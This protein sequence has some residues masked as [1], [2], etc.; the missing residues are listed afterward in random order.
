MKLKGK[1][2]I[3]DNDV[4]LTGTHLGET[5]DAVLNKQQIEIDSLKGNVKWIY[6]NGGVGGKGGSGG[7]GSGDSWSI[8]ATLDNTQLKSNNIILNGPGIYKLVVKINKPGGGNFKCDVQYKNENGVQN[9][10]SSYLNIDNVFT[11]TYNIQ[12][13]INDTINVTITDENGETKQVNAMYIVN[14]Y[15]F[16]IKYTKN[17][18]QEYYNEDNDIFM[19]DIVENGLGIKINYSI[20]IKAS[21]Q[22]K[23]SKFDGTTTD[24]I[25][26]D[27]VQGSGESPLLKIAEDAFYADSSNAGYYT[28]HVIIEITPENQQPTTIEK[29]LSCNLI[30]RNLYL[31]IKTSTGLIYRDESEQNPYQFSPGNVTFYLQPYQGVNLNRKYTLV[32]EIN[33][34]EDSSNSGILNERSNTEY[35]F[36]MQQDGWNKIK[37][38]LYSSNGHGSYSV[39]KYLYIYNSNSNLNFDTFAKNS[40]LRV[41]HLSTNNQSEHCQPIFESNAYLSMNKLNQPK[42]VNWTINSSQDLSS[43]L[44]NIGFELSRTVSEDEPLFIL[45][46]IDGITNS[47]DTN[48]IYIYRNKIKIGQSTTLDI[49][50]PACD[51]LGENKLTNYHL[52][53]IHK[54]YYYTAPGSNTRYFELLV[55]IDGKLENTTIINANPTYSKLVF[56]NST[57]NCNFLD[58]LQ[59]NTTQEKDLI[60]DS[61]VAEYFYTWV[62]KF[63][64]QDLV[65]NFNDMI[66]VHNTIHNKFKL[67]SGDNNKMIEIDIAAV[68][69][70]A[71]VA[72][73][74]ILLLKVQDIK[75]FQQGEGVQNFLK[76]YQKKYNQEESSG[77]M[78]VTVFYS[79]NKSGLQEYT[80]DGG[81]FTI[82]VQ[83]SSTKQ[84]FA[85]N[86][87]LGVE[88][89]TSDSSETYI[90][91][92]NFINES[93]P[94]YEDKDIHNTFLPET[95]FTLKADKVDSSHCNNNA[96]GAF[97]NDHTVKFKTGDNGKYKNY[98][99]NCLTGFA[100]LLFVQTNYRDPI[101]QE[102]STHVYYLGVYNFNLGRKSY[103]NLGYKSTDNLKT[104]GLKNGFGIYKINKDLNNKFVDGLNV[105]EV[106]DND[107][108]W[109]F[110]Q[111]DKL[112]LSGYND[113]DKGMYDDFVSNDTSI[114]HTNDIEKLSEFTKR[115]SLAGGYAF[116]QMGKNF[117][118]QEDKYNASVYDTTHI[119]VDKYKSINQV[120]DYRQQYTR[121]VDPILNKIVYTEKERINEA[122]KEDLL[123]CVAGNI[124][125]GIPA[126]VDYQSL[127]EYYVIC[128]AFGMLDSVQ[129]NL[130]VK[131]WNGGKTYYIAFYDM[132]T[133]L[134]KDNDGKKVGYFAYSDYWTILTESAELIDA[135]VQR[136]F[137]PKGIVSTVSFFDVPS[138]YLFAIAKYASVVLDEG[139]VTTFPLKLWAQFR[140][141]IVDPKLHKGCLKNADYFIDNYFSKRLNTIGPELLNFNYRAKYL[142]KEAN[143][144]NYISD[145]GS[146]QGPGVYKVKDWLNSRLH[147]L[148]VYMGLAST[149]PSHRLIQRY[150]K[151][152]SSW[153]SLKISGT[154]VYETELDSQEIP[155]NNPDIIIYK[156]IFSKGE[157]RKYSNTI[158]ISIKVLDQSFLV[159]AKDASVSRY[160]LEDSTKTYSIKFD[161]SGAQ[162]MRLGGSDRWTYISNLAPFYIGSTNIY[163]NSYNLK[164]FNFDKAILSGTNC[165]GD[166]INLPSCEEIIFSNAQNC[167]NDAQINNRNFPIV[168][169]ID[170]STSKMGNVS[171]QN[172]PLEKF[173]GKDMKSISLSIAN[174]KLQVLDLSDSTFAGEVFLNKVLGNPILNNLQCK[175]LTIY[176]NGQDLIINNNYLLEELN[177][178]GFRKIYVDNCPKLKTFQCVDKGQ[179]NTILQDLK[180]TNC[181]TSYTSLLRQY[182]DLSKCKALEW[183][184]M[185]NTKVF[186]ALSISHD[187][188]LYP[189]A[190]ENTNLTHIAGGY[191]I[192]IIITGPNTFKNTPYKLSDIENFIIS[193]DNN[194]TN[195]SSMFSNEIGTGEFDMESVQQFIQYAEN[196]EHVTN[197]NYLFYG[198]KNI[199]TTLTPV[200]Y[201]TGIKLNRFKKVKSA[202]GVFAKTQYDMINKDMFKDFGD[203]IVDMNGFFGPDNQNSSESNKYIRVLEHTGL[204]DLLLKI[205]SL[206]L[207]YIYP[208]YRTIKIVNTSNQTVENPNIVELFN[209][210][211]VNSSNIQSISNFNIFYDSVNNI[212]PNYNNLFDSPNWS[213][214]RSLFSS[215]ISIKIDDYKNLK[216]KK[217]QL[218]SVSRSLV[219]IYTNTLIDMFELLNWEYYLTNC[220]NQEVIGDAFDGT[221]KY[222]TK[223]NWDKIWTYISQ[224]RNL[225][226]SISYL[227]TRTYLVGNNAS[228]PVV[229][230][231]IRSFY[232]TFLNLRIINDITGVETNNQLINLD[233]EYMDIDNYPT[234]F[235]RAVNWYGAFHSCKILKVPKY[236]FFNKRKKVITPVYKV[237]IDGSGIKSNSHTKI[238]LITY[239]YDKVI[240]NLKQTFESVQFKE[241]TYNYQSFNLSNSVLQ[242]LDGNDL[243]DTEYYEKVN[244][245]ILKT[246]SPNEYDYD[247]L[248]P[249]TCI[250]ETTNYTNK[251]NQQWINTLK[252]GWNQGEKLGQ[253]IL[254]P[255]FFAGCTEGCNICN[256]FKDS[257]LIGS[258][259]PNLVQGLKAPSDST[260]CLVGLNILPTFYGEFT[261]KHNNPN[262]KKKRVY[263]FV[264]ENFFNMGNINN[265]IGVI[266]RIPN[267]QI[268][269]TSNQE[270]VNYYYLLLDT[271]FKIYPT[272]YTDN[273]NLYGFIQYFNYGEI[274]INVMFNTK[275]ISNN[276][277]GE[278]GWSIIQTKCDSLFNNSYM[279]AASGNLFINPASKPINSWIINNYPIIN[280]SISS[281]GCIFPI[282]TV[283]LRN[284]IKYYHNQAIYIKNVPTTSRDFY[285]YGTQNII[286]N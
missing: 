68:K 117:G 166:Q 267:N 119:E 6:Q 139:S 194:C 209:N 198:Q 97:V 57:Y 247:I 155:V 179:D 77:S 120:P 237:T 20:G 277:C 67:D 196:L 84:N 71:Q 250:Y 46:D 193:I 153:E 232:F 239:I 260:G 121:K 125:Q 225:P 80:I 51:V 141:D 265:L 95:S 39:T 233:T 135:T 94:N 229:L 33:D 191:H 8:Y 213:N 82:T 69:N 256:T 214:L 37:F 274:P 210:S 182:L 249:T 241:N 186:I 167:T 28:S 188:K 30:P 88:S 258:L 21:V 59:F 238:N 25:P 268:S 281:Q 86:L 140:S 34:V 262:I 230:N 104:I 218:N 273:N 231:N 123:H 248:H 174:S 41:H 187:L 47:L 165:I 15:D 202:V 286:F 12:L 185:Q 109:D 177:A 5:L 200:S 53:T 157:D 243:T 65:P 43:M 189:S 66:A 206:N 56:N 45:K 178:Y 100:C 168:K 278:D 137:Q 169:T 7:S 38:T 79:Q 89:T 76:W 116:T 145:I 242:T 16:S 254:P 14:P 131:S 2:I 175:K 208:M 127:I 133:A 257:N 106:Q 164:N 252:V 192:K 103:Y 163:I 204:N 91:T 124:D 75:N 122:T 85:K 226:Y 115:V 132:D 275:L 92:P 269:D 172:V 245:T 227:F 114:S 32:T 151:A 285:R 171:I 18:G 50:F 173:Y 156:D 110:S 199:N 264:P 54:K 22:Y 1:N 190:F 3:T 180:I 99:K 159:V 111:F 105:A 149:S 31:K 72:E 183:F 48:F 9:P 10:P 74:P 134:G 207:F 284:I 102:V 112:I 197:I 98:V 81:K 176:G 13:G 107:P 19:E 184:S 62:F 11:T 220:S 44:F 240:N 195:I 143:H 259:P 219:N 83:G 55:Y 276:T 228:I 148:D 90:Y 26:L 70:L 58:L 162:N 144:V 40:I 146:F 150:N 23:Y 263:S 24:F 63:N 61:D 113:A 221:T 266:Y 147:I 130:N 101:S 272:L 52:L 49:Y 271:S 154:E 4:T 223:Q 283:N 35:T 211:D 87:E 244:S 36:L 203:G 222:I 279:Q 96:I 60:S 236:N 136:D 270:I 205:N 93:T 246:L 217:L 201:D 29:Q 78:D 280:I 212:Y 158:D 27:F 138:S 234:Y 170:L 215:F 282:A 64:K 160:Y 17:N 126:Y 235:P 42:E 118:K 152:T 251:D 181:G 128:M 253:Y 161:P 108:Y 142:P 129:K 73:S 216:L 261:F 255:D 224:N